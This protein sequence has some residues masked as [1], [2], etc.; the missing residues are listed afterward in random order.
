MKKHMKSIG[1]GLLLAALLVVAIG[2]AAFAAGGRSRNFADTDGDGVCDNLGTG[3]CTS[4]CASTGTGCGRN[5]NF[6]DSDG[7]GICDN[8]GN[9]VCKGTGAGHGIGHHGG[10]RSG[11]RR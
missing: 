3:I 4:A 7:D 8:L 11:C 9:G 2:G 1:I 10:W 5:C 6:V